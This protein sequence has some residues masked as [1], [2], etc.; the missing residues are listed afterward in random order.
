M[1]S[2]SHP[3]LPD[4]TCSVWNSWSI[5]SQ[6]FRSAGF[7]SMQAMTRLLL[8]SSCSKSWESA[9]CCQRLA[10]RIW[11][12]RRKLWQRLHFTRSYCASI[13]ISWVA[14]CGLCWKTIIC[15]WPQLILETL[16]REC[17]TP[18]IRQT[19]RIVTL[20][21][22][23]RCGKTQTSSSSSGCPCGITR[24]SRLC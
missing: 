8:W 16:G 4:D 17:K 5:S 12:S 3:W 24:R 18:G 2:K 20:C 23:A 9:R 15:G 21:R 7:P 11:P 22:L 14:S 6:H 19:R 10:R 1:K 13:R